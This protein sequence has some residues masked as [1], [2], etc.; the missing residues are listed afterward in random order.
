MEFLHDI[1]HIAFFYSAS[2]PKSSLYLIDLLYRLKFPLGK[3]N[4]ISFFV[5]VFFLF[6]SS[7]IRKLLHPCR[8]MVY[9]HGYDEQEDYVL[10]PQSLYIQIKWLTSMKSLMWFIWNLMESVKLISSHFCL[11]IL[12]LQDFKNIFGKKKNNLRSEDLKSLRNESTDT[13][14]EFL[15]ILSL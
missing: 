8:H 10:N 7:E 9:T 15:Q 11:W 4:C 1:L 3:N 2:I 5:F 6:L 12:R 14:N 13:N